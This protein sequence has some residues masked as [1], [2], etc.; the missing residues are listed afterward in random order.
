[1]PTE[2]LGAPSVFSG[3]GKQGSPSA[4]TEG[5]R[6][7]RCCFFWDQAHSRPFAAG[8]AFLTPSAADKSEPRTPTLAW[9]G[10]GKRLT[11]VQQLNPLSAW[12]GAP[13]RYSRVFLLV[14]VDPG[15]SSRRGSC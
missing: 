4:V 15:D 7:F 2:R 6:D 12:K 13:G 9:A 3:L 10:S 1:M 8:L 5:P 11:P 14:G